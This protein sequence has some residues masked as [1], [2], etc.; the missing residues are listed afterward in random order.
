MLSTMQ[1]GQLSIANLLR[2]GSRVHAAREAPGVEVHAYDELLA[3]QP[4]E[5]A[6]PE[7]DERSA[8]SMCYTSGTTGDPK[9]VSYSHRSIWLH[10]MQ[11]CMTDSMRLAEH[12]KAMAIVPMF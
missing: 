7:V 1:D 9:G 2:H 11:V 12:D 4:D 10:S 6:W 3:A 5:F 8:A